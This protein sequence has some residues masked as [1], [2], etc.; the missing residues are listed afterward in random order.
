MLDSRNPDA[1]CACNRVDPIIWPVLGAYAS[2]PLWVVWRYERPKPD[3]DITKVP[4]QATRPARQ[5]KNNDSSTWSDAATALRTYTLTRAFDG[6]G[7]NILGSDICAFDID[8]CRNPENGLLHPWAQQ[9]VERAQTYAEVTPSCRG[10]RII[11]RGSGPKVHRT[12]LKVADGV[13]CEAYRDAE[14]YIT[15]TGNVLPDAPQVLND[16]GALI[17]E[18]VAEL[19][20]Q[21]ESASGEGESASTEGTAEL[22]PMLVSLLHIPNRGAKQPH[23]GYSSR[24]ELLFAFVTGALR[25]R[26]SDTAITTACLDSARYGCA[27]YEH[28]KAKGGQAYVAKQI[29]HA[30]EKTFDK[31]IADI[32]KNHALVLAGNK[33]AIMKLEGKNRFRLLQITAF[34]HWFA[35]QRITVGKKV[36]SVADHWLAHKQRRQYE[37]IEFAPSDGQQGYYNLWRGFSVEPRAGD[38]SKF[39]DH[40]KDNVAQGNV[41]LYNWIIGWFAQIVQQ[42][43]AKPGTALCLRGKQGV[44]KTKVGQV[45]GSLFEDHYELVADPRY[46]V[47]QFNAHMAQQ[48]LLHADEAFWAGDKRAEGKLKDLVTGFKHRL[49]F[50]GVDPIIVQNLIRLFVTGNQDWLVAAGFGERRFAVIDVGEAHKEDHPYFAAID[51]EMSDGGREALLHHLLNFDLATVDLRTIPKTEALLE[52]IIET[53]TPEQAWW[54]DTLK[55]GKLPWGIA[56]TNTCPKKTLFRRY[57]QHAD[58]QGVRRRAIEVKIGIFLTR[59]VGPGLKSDQ[60]KRYSIYHRNGHRLNETGWIYTFPS[61]ADCRQRFAQEIQQDLVWEDP[62]AD[63]VHEEEQVEDDDVPF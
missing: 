61:L 39:L 38:C 45:F 7:L 23:G 40:I 15:V 57:V 35:N 46:I 33:S 12:Q 55:Q 42:P 16:I 32:N 41:A 36:V 62:G 2:Q 54:L 53:A 43:T 31:E 14:R 58:L 13:K 22:P 47:G 26:V 3:A 51:K 8:G 10:I 52:Q 25:A 49:E 24:S 9:L 50:K 28:C 6:I 29:K 44:G 20:T 48:L 5:A 17:D 1:R 37:G 27:V 59:Y 4:Y 30:K 19:G 11:G 56:E 21:G 60:K 34:Q 63:W 18:V